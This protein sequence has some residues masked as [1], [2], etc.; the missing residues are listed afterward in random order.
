MSHTS[1]IHLVRRPMR[2]VHR[3][4]RRLVP[5]GART[6][7]DA[8]RPDPGEP[9]VGRVRFG[10]LRRVHPVSRDFGFRRGGPVDRYYIEGFLA[11]HAADIRGRVLEIA[12]DAYTRQFGG[13]RVTR[14]DVLHAVP[15]N[16]HA[17][18][19]GDLAAGDGIPTGVFDCIVCTQTL[20]CIY[21]V[22]SAVRTLQRSLR[23][24]GVALVTLPGICQ[25]ARYDIERWGDF[26]RFTDLA[27]RRLFEE[28]F[29]ADQVQVDTYGNILSAIAFLH[30]LAARELHAAELDAHD[31]D[32]QVTIA[33]RA[34]R[35]EGI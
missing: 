11:R 1:M 9:P 15:G 21:D 20:L 4:L 30:G 34:A 35:P 17:T 27:A 24:G 7:R 13:D 8:P 10:D 33:V 14:S 19:V 6:G 28:A 31:P 32:Y 2:R 25:I 26:W 3:L 23:P 12:D 5:A 18:L 22:R 29:P 16:P